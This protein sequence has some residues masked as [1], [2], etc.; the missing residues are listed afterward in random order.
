MAQ[1]KKKEVEKAIKITENDTLVPQI[2]SNSNQISG[3]G[4]IAKPKLVVKEQVKA[5]KP[6]PVLLDEGNQEVLNDYID[7][8]FTKPIKPKLQDKAIQLNMPPITKKRQKQKVA[9][10]IISKQPLKKPSYEISKDSFKNSSSININTSE[11]FVSSS[12][13]QERVSHSVIEGEDTD[14]SQEQQFEENL[15]NLNKIYEK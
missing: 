15:R 6:K 2:K 1:P 11:S 9:Q 12:Q 3:Q 14:S 7:F 10:P 13:V 4:E 5:S 8:T